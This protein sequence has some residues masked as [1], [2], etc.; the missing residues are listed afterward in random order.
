MS[1]LCAAITEHVQ[2]ILCASAWQDQTYLVMPIQDLEPLLRKYGVR[3]YF[4]GHEHCLEHLHVPGEPTHY[5][6]SGGGSLTDYEVML[7]DYGGS[8]WQHQGS[9]D[10]LYA[11][12]NTT[13][14]G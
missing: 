1:S 10:V 7:T 14:P 12:L 8:Q 2:R 5:F 11:H 9:G 4:S 6:V 13:W 3:A